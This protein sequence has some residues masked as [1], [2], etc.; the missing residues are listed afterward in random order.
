M[1]LSKWQSAADAAPPEVPGA[2]STGY[3]R[4]GTPPD[5]A[6]TWPGAY[7]FYQIQASF[8]NLLDWAEVVASHL[9]LT[10]LRDAIRIIAGCN[11]TALTVAGTPYTLTKAHSGYISVD[12]SGGA[13]VIN[14]PATTN[15]AGFFYQFIRTDTSGNAV[16]INRAGA[17][18][19]DGGGTSYTLNPYGRPRFV[20]AGAGVWRSANFDVATNAE[21][22]TG[23][24][25]NKLVSVAGLASLVATDA[26]NGLTQY[27]DATEMEAGTALDRSV[28]PGMQHRHPSAAKGWVQRSSGTTP[29]ALASNNVSSLGDGGVGIT[30]V[31]WTNVFSS[32]NYAKAG[33]NDV[34][35][36]EHSCKISGSASA[37]S[38]V[39]NSSHHPTDGFVLGD[40]SISVVAFGDQ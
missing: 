23:T 16:T 22:A 32:V 21:V 10:L 11:Y 24:A 26:L 15:M 30:T 8:K 17:D 39:L 27:A 7:W 4:N 20:T 9:T 37:S 25:T 14:L 33:M 1:D 35:S 31:N 19:F 36:A 38:V 6:P 40:G 13:V 5:T 2:F 12:A 18:T 3:P 28:P 29:T 34:G